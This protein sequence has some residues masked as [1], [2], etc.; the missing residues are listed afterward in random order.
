MNRTRRQKN[1]IVKV[2]VFSMSQ[3]I[4]IQN[5]ECV[6]LSKD[7]QD[8]VYLNSRLSNHWKDLSVGKRYSLDHFRMSWDWLFKVLINIT[9]I[10]RNCF[11]FSFL[12]VIMSRNF[13]YRFCDIRKKFCDI[14]K[15][16]F[17]KNPNVTKYFLS[18]NTKFF[19]MSPN[20]KISLHYETNGHKTL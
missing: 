5:L 15:L 10:H 11:K 3:M 1:E 2:Y 19:L 7:E 18:F 16:M 17:T 9:P 12:F 14:R 13:P 20:R 4:L 8:E 6:L